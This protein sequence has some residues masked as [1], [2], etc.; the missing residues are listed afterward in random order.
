VTVKIRVNATTCLLLEALRRAVSS[1]DEKVLLRDCEFKLTSKSQAAQPLLFYACKATGSVI[2]L[3]DKVQIRARLCLV[4]YERSLPGIDIDVW[5][6]CERN[7][8]MER[9]AFS[10]NPQDGHLR[11]TSALPPINPPRHLAFP[12]SA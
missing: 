11:T 10:Y 7:G 12:K 3:T 2:E 9:G 6:E 1:L 8:S 5:I 4:K